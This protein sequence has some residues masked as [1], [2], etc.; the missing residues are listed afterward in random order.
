MDYV[1]ELYEEND[2]ADLLL[3]E[4]EFSETVDQWLVTVGF[5]LSDQKDSSLS[6]IVP[7]K[8]DP[9]LSRRYKVINV[10]NKTGRPLS[11]KMRL[12]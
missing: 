1:R 8:S 3:E 6:L 12:V 10:D 7:N 9:L 4:V 2:I 11:M 5:S